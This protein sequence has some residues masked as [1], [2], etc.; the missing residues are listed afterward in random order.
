MIVRKKKNQSA[1]ELVFCFDF[2]SL[3]THTTP[4]FSTGAPS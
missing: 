1:I 4:F 2:F 3:K